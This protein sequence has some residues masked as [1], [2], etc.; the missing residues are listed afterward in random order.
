M[1]LDFT[2]F[3][4]RI[5]STDEKFEPLIRD[6]KKNY[7]VNSKAVLIS[8]THVFPLHG[9]EIMNALKEARIQVEPIILPS[10]ETSKRLSSAE[11]CWERMHAFGLERTSF[12][13][14]L[15]GGV[16]T[17]LS[18][19]VASCY[20]RGIDSLLVPTTLM[21]MVDAAIGGKTAVN[22]PSGKNLVGTF[23]QP[24]MILIAPHL[25][26]SLPKRELYSGLAEVIKS[27]V[28]WDEDF[29]KYLETHLETILNEGPKKMR[30][31]IERTV[32]IKAEI[33]AKDEKEKGIRAILNWGHTVAHALETITRYEKYLHGEAVAIGISAEAYISRELGL[34]DDSFINR[35]ESLCLAANLPTRLPK[36]IDIDKLIDLMAG[37]KKAVGGK[38]N[39]ILARNIG[40]VEKID[41]IDRK[42]IK[43]ALLSMPN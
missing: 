31:L 26:N 33:V 43:K 40:Q 20:M 4:S 29:F 35:Q 2:L 10:G 6:L 34:V 39:M 3:N 1:A 21:G 28:I 25:L 42:A 15:G 23:Y 19:F 38:I 36:E 37:D 27:A 12:V 14:G 41:D 17:D 30:P 24:K 32:M 18:G 9:Q 5:V 7:L 8:D 22:L 16:I 11:L 13:L